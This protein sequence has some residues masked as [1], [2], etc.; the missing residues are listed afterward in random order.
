MISARTLFGQFSASPHARLRLA[1][2][3]AL[4]AAAVLCGCSFSERLP[5]L[6]EL[7]QSDSIQQSMSATAEVDSG[8]QLKEN[9]RIDVGDPLALTD[10]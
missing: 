2:A 7:E 8:D 9:A 4:L 5:G 10:P 1:A 6:T 3:G